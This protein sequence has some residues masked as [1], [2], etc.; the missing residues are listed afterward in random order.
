MKKWQ[1]QQINVK[2]IGNI[3]M[4]IWGVGDKGGGCGGVGVVRKEQL[5]Y[6]YIISPVGILHATKYMT[7]VSSYPLIFSF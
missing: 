6:H 7:C 5:C 3:L 2:T 1:H 4:R